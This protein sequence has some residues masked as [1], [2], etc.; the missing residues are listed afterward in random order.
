M[1]SDVTQIGKIDMFCDFT[2]GENNKF[3]KYGYS[4]DSGGC[5]KKEG[6]HDRTNILQ[7]FCSKRR[8]CHAWGDSNCGSE[9]NHAG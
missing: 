7:E 9:E 8:Q 1:T 2:I 6:Q 4:P 3:K 5:P